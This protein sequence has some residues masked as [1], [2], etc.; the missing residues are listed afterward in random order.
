M[1]GE[2]SVVRIKMEEDRMGNAAGLEGETAVVII[3][4]KRRTERCEQAL[5]WLE[6]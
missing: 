3:T 6:R 4:E 2:K 1:K 5:R